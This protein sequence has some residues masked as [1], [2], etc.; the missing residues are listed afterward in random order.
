MRGWIGDGARALVDKALGEPCSDAVWSHFSYEYADCCGTSSRL[1]PGTRR[2]LDRL[3]AQG[4]KLAVLTN[5]EA[6]FS[7][8]L[9]TLHDITD[10]FDLLVAG[11][12]LPFKKPDPR[13]VAHALDALH[14]HADEAAFVGDSVTD[15]RTARAAG[16]RAWIVRGGYPGG[17]FAGSDQPDAFIDG[18]D[19]FDPAAQLQPID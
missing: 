13:V 12:S 18:F 9:L 10:C 2:L 19:R 17:E 8:K 7:H 16:L 15:V 3:R 11:D 14:V 6:A 5:K 1:Y 4:L